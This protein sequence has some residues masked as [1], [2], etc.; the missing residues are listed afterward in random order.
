VAARADL[1]V[2]WR[3]H[4]GHGIIHARL[5]GYP[6]RVIAS[7]APLRAAA[8]AHRGSLVATGGALELVRQVDVWGPVPALVVMRRL[9]DQFDPRGTLN[10]GRYVG[11]I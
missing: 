5:A 3:A 9:K 4:A 6:E 11:G 2:R 10:P 1:S 7:V 8:L